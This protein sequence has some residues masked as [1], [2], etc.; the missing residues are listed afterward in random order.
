MTRIFKDFEESLNYV[1]KFNATNKDSVAINLHGDSI[2]TECDQIILFVVITMKKLA[3]S[4]IFELYSETLGMPE[5]CQIL[6]NKFIRAIEEYSCEFQ[7]LSISEWVIVIK[8]NFNDSVILKEFVN[9]SKSINSK[10][11][12]YMS[13]HYGKMPIVN[14]QPSKIYKLNNLVRIGVR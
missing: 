12:A 1:I 10:L 3:T 5:N 14:C 6:I 9:Q 11:T 13:E 4:K 7:I 8:V 2:W